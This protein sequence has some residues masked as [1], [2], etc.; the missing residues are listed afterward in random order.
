M[1]EKDEKIKI[2][3]DV[4]VD[5]FRNE[6]K[7]SE[8]QE[9]DESFLQDVL[10]Y[11][12]EKQHA[13]EES[14][15]E[16]ELFVD[17]DVK[18]LERQLNNIRKIISSLYEKREEKIIKMA[19]NK[20]KAK[21]AIIDTS[22]ML[23]HEKKLFESLVFTLKSFREIILESILKLKEP[24]FPKELNFSVGGNNKKKKIKVRFLQ[25]IPNFVD[26]D[27]KVYGPYDVNEI[28]LLPENVAEILLKKKKVEIMK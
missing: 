25:P 24:E 1:S 27:G 17:E 15:K 14:L 13:Y 16:S 9:L 21:N 23:E 4:L 28:D 10:D 22:K 6:K 12:K 8:L 2:T 7:Q 19:I 5:L 26:V 18:K 3:Y 11:L 20:A